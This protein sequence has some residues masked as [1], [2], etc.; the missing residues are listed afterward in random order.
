LGLVKRSPSRS[1]HFRQLR[2]VRRPGL[3]SVRRLLKTVGFILDFWIGSIRN[4]GQE[5]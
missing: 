1:L 4:D 3:T 2:G 5:Y